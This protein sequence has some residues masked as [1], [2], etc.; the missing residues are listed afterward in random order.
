MFVCYYYGMET[1]VINH[2]ENH[3]DIEAAFPFRG[4]DGTWVD[5]WAVIICEKN[6]EIL[7]AS[8]SIR[9]ASDP[10]RH[11]QDLSPVMEAANTPLGEETMN[12]W[13]PPILCL[14]TECNPLAINPIPFPLSSFA[15]P[16][17]SAKG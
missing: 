5:K 3:Y 9:A 8:E 10:G 13:T 12:G 17:V 2:D 4:E 1:R 15:P 14:P 6:E 16:G 7:Q 11:I